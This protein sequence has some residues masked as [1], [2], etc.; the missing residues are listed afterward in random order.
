MSVFLDH[1]RRAMS[2]QRERESMARESI[3]RDSVARE[4]RASVAREF[5]VTRSLPA[6]REEP[7]LR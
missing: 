6:T 3:L 4:I 7:I 1:H 5:S 2:V